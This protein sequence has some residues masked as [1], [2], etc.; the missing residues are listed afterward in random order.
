MEKADIHL[1]GFFIVTAL[2]GDQGLLRIHA[3]LA[4]HILLRFWLSCGRIADGNKII[5]FFKKA[6]KSVKSQLR[7]FTTLLLILLNLEPIVLRSDNR[8]IASV[9]AMRAVLFE[10]STK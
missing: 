1:Q 10:N 6:T 2:Q 8:F 4:L 5:N 3:Q 9:A 7:I